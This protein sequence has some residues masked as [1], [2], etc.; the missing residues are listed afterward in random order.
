MSASGLGGAFCAL[1]GPLDR[2]SGRARGQSEC[3]VRRSDHGR[4]VFPGFGA[5]LC[6]PCFLS[7]LGTQ[8][9]AVK[10]WDPGRHLTSPPG[11]CVLY[12]TVPPLSRVPCAGVRSPQ[13]RG[14]GACGRCRDAPA[15]VHLTGACGI[16][17]SGEDS[18]V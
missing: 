4:L 13:G 14:G 2:P 8:A 17:R 1:A 15:R 6:T 11:L 18:R 3:G 5:S 9:G 7:L 10:T 16:S 12:S